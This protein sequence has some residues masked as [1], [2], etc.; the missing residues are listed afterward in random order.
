MQHKIHHSGPGVLTL[1]PHFVS[2]SRPQSLV[3]PVSPEDG[4]ERKLSEALKTQEGR[5]TRAP[6]AVSAKLRQEKEQ[7]EPGVGLSRART[8]TQLRVGQEN[9]QDGERGQDAVKG[10]GNPPGHQHPEPASEKK[11]VVKGR[12]WDKEG[13]GVGTPREEPRKEVGEPPKRTS[14]ELG[15]CR[16]REVKILTGQ[17]SRS[18]EEKTALVVNA[19]QDQQVSRNRQGTSPWGESSACWEDSRERESPKLLGGKWDPWALGEALRA[20]IYEVVDRV[21]PHPFHPLHVLF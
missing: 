1:T 18:V 21:S 9:I 16:L 13:Q 12:L 15:G 8:G 7:Q 17:G 19:S 3:K 6:M 5:R 14:P 4:E 20:V 11:A 2:V 10:R